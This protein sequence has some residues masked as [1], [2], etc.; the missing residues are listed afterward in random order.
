MNE[1]V[2]HVESLEKAKKVPDYILVRSRWVM[3]KKEDF[4]HRDVRART[5]GGEVKKSG[6]KFDAFNASTP[7]LEDKKMLFS[8]FATE[9][10]TRTSTQALIC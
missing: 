4:D 7:P 2:W 8:Q 3:A 6:E 1:K 10:E 5:C 9:R